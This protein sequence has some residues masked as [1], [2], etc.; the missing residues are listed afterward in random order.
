MMRWGLTMPHDARQIANAIL[1][2]S[3]REGFKITNLALNKIVFFAHGWCLATRG[4]PLV[5]SVFEA[6]QFGPVH[7]QI[8]RQLKEFRDGPITARLTR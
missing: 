8:Y 4:E 6:W 5:D 3:S 2:V 1:D 7:P